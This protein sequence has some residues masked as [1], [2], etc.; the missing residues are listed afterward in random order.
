VAN[1]DDDPQPEGPLEGSP[2]EPQTPDV[3]PASPEAPPS[4]WRTGKIRMLKEQEILGYAFTGRKVQG[5]VA[6]R[7]AGQALAALDELVSM[8]A[9][10]IYGQVGKRGPAQLPLGMGALRLTN[11]AWGSAAF[12]F[13]S[14]EGEAFQIAPVEEARDFTSQIDGVIDQLLNIVQASASDEILET[15]RLYNDRVAAK[16]VQFLEVIVEE[17]VNVM[18]ETPT[19]SAS[20][21]ISHANRALAALERTDE[22]RVETTIV[23]GTLYEANAR[24]RGF[25][26]LQD[27]GRL[28]QGHFA[29]DLYPVVGDAWNQR[30]SA[31]IAIRVEILARSG[32]ERRKFELVSLE[33]LAPGTK[34]D[35]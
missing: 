28:L 32:D 15:A 1:D 5:S 31:T 34:T 26:L 16:Y 22:I 14:G 8:L 17:G 9:A 25:R 24:S 20:L 30:V 4:P 6:V 13:T 21:P 12:Y 27:D 23:T 19:R 2:Q 7:F 10:S 35:D 33:T 18:W 11:V 29:E 3:E